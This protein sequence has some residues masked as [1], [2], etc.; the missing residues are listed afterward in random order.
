MGEFQPR[1]NPN[2]WLDDLLKPYKDALEKFKDRL[3][4]IFGNLFPDIDPGAAQLISDGVILFLQITLAVISLIAVVFILIKLFELLKDWLANRHPLEQVRP[5]VGQVDGFW[6]EGFEKH[7][8]L[9]QA[10]LKEQ[11][12]N[13]A[14]RQYYFSLIGL[15]DETKLWPFAENRSR[16]DYERRLSRLHS[17]EPIHTDTH[18]RAF[19]LELEDSFAQVAKPYEIGRF[20]GI[21]LDERDARHAEESVHRFKSLADKLVASHQRNKTL[22]KSRESAQ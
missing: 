8:Q 21:L 18:A 7:R 1:E 17:E 5:V 22:I 14:V 4:E 15:L 13:E 9:G 2:Q 19:G 3:D 10:A 12:Y 16:A 6:I 20:G 11:R